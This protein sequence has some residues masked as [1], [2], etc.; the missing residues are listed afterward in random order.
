MR[1]LLLYSLYIATG[2]GLAVAISRTIKS[3]SSDRLKGD[4]IELTED[5]LRTIYHNADREFV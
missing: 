5:R 1:N 4:T 3:H 2:I